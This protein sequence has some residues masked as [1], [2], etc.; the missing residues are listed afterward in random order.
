MAESG[1]ISTGTVDTSSYA[2]P[3]PAQ[4]PLDIAGK[5]GG[6]EQQRQSIEATNV[7]IDQNKLRLANERFGLLSK[8][9][10][11]LITD[12]DVS[13]DKVHETINNLVRMGIIPQET[14]AA[15]SNQVPTDPKQIA[16][17]LQRQISRAQTIQE[18]VNY[19]Y[20]VPSTLNR[21]NDL[22]PVRVSPNPAVGIQQ[23]GDPMRLGLPPTTRQVPTD[24]GP[25][26]YIGDRSPP[27]GLPVAP[28]Y[29]PG[30]PT[31]VLGLPAGERPLPAAAPSTMNLPAGAPGPVAQVAPAGPVA[32]GRPPGFAEGLA[33][34]D[35]DQRI[36]GNLAT[37]NV[38]AMQALSLMKD[39][40]TGPLTGEFNKV[41]AGLKAW[42]LVPTDINDPTVAY[43]EV[44]KKL[45]QFVKDSPGASRSDA[46]QAQAILSNPNPRTQLNRTLI[47]LTQ[48]AVVN[49]V[50]RILQPNDFTSGRFNEYGAHRASFVNSI[51][52]R[53]IK[54]GLGFMPDN[55]RRA[56][57]EEMDK[58]YEEG[59]PE[60][61]KFR[62]SLELID[63]YG[64]PKAAM[65]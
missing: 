43:Q 45:A 39:L 47:N 8:E 18:A 64:I 56:L 24:G 11:T 34:R 63:K 60:G 1:G 65:P 29:R 33:Q 28:G 22:I 59:K 46:A 38:P 51:D 17:F 53:G 19:H 55:E 52:P 37:Q 31:S 12:P 30:G 57:L 23:M 62:K 20:G 32:A 61:I 21:G 42:G 54:V 7:G 35:E 9:L 50:M 10:S 36:A 6:L 4:S 13:S 26:T 14:A 40:R 58:K 25:E 2:R 44:E 15:F 41:V 3:L 27:T 49:N 5:L 48:D 16:P